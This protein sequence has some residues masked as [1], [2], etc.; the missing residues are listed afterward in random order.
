MP[1]IKVFTVEQA[2]RALPLVRRIV[3]DIVAEHPQWK[4]L[5]ARYELAAA[6]A[7]P[8]WGESPEQLKLRGEIDT[9]A[10]RINGYVDELAEVGCLLK[11]FEDGLVDFYGHQEGRLVFLCWRLGEERVAHWHD[12]DAGFAGRRPIAPAFAAT[13]EGQS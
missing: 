3:Q 7:R 13:E 2:N 8:E 6:G 9:V 10:R 12:L 4:D 1:D 11:R 5:V